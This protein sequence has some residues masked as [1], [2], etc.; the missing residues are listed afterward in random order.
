MQPSVKYI[1]EGRSLYVAYIYLE[2]TYDRTDRNAMCRMLEMYGGNGN[3]LEANKSL[4][5]ECEICV[6]VC[7]Q[8]SHWF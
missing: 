4:Y 7:R 2:S 1:S 5:A 3:L 6:G 8:E